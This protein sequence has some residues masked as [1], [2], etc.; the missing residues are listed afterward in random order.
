M[1]SNAEVFPQHITRKNIGSHQ[2]FDGIAV[3]DHSTLHLRFGAR[4][5]QAHIKRLLQIDVEWNHAPLNV[6]VLD[7]HLLLAVVG[8][9]IDF[10]LAGRELLNFYDQLVFK[11]LAR[12][13][14]VA[15]LQGVCHS[16]DPVM[17]LDQQILALNLFARGVFLRRVKIFDDLEHK[18]E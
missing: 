1:A 15:V 9:N 16:A 13:S 4:F 3:F 5:L 2:I 11:S 7:H 17:L 14:H 12:K 18:R 8:P 10:N 6:S